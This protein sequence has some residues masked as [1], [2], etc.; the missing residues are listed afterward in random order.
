[1][2]LSAQLEIPPLPGPFDCT[3]EH[4]LKLPGSKSITNRALVLAA[5][6]Q[7]DSVLDGVLFSDDTKVMLEALQGLGFRLIVDQQARRVTVHGRAGVIPRSDVELFCGNSGTT[8]RFLTALCCLGAPGSKYVLT[9][10]PRMLERPIGELVK[11]LKDLGARIDY[12][13]NEGYPP[14][15]VHGGTLQS[16]KLTLQPTLSSQYITALLQVGPYLPKG[17]TLNFDG[18][19]TSRPYVEMTTNVMTDFGSVQHWQDQ[20]TAVESGHYQGHA[21]KIEPDASNASY[22]LATLAVTPGSILALPRL[23]HQSVQG[24][25]QF[26]DCISQMLRATTGLKTTWDQQGMWLQHTSNSLS[27]SAIDIDLNDMPDMAQTLAVVALFAKGKTIIRNV[28]NLRVKE[29]DRIAALQKELTKLGATVEVTGDN[30]AIQPPTNQPQLPYQP[31][32]PVVIK[33]YDDHRM[34]MAFTV[35]GLASDR[36]PG[37]PRIIID[38]PACVNKTFPDY[39]D[40]IQQLRDRSADHT[41]Q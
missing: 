35:A 19:I 30:I 15:R 11:M 2:A 14:I 7:G 3:G 37:Q 9:G 5:L 20:T 23:T 13:G 16:G 25:S 27:L 31:G 40:Y 10:I 29:T 32:E 33:T 38:D 17:L 36:L 22:F 18:N 12:L 24:D 39:F 6:A 8:I 41:I 26:I 28:G 34:A 21:Y 4:A 1:M